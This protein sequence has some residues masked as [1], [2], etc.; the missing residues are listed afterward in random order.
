M[1][2]RRPKRQG[3]A[4][5]N[6][7]GR[8]SMN[9]V[10][11]A[12][13]RVACDVGGTFTDVCVLDEA[14][15]Q[16]RVAKTPTTPDP[17]DGVLEGIKAGGVDLRDMVLFAHGTT[18]ATNALI[19]RNFPP[20]DHGHHQGLP[21]RDR[22]PPRH[23]RRPVGHLQG[24]GAALHPAPQPTR[25]KRAHRL[26]RRR[27]RAGERGG[28]AGG[29]PHHQQAWRHDHRCLLRQR[30]RQSRERAPHARHSRRGSPRRFHLA[31]QRDHA[32]DLR[33]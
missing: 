30:L 17:I 31:L 12:A 16:M 2:R 3:D 1:L 26:Q 18:L 5:T 13:V 25:C 29:R 9:D 32:G 19:T 27:H 6:A 10:S 24:N 8:T 7:R 11:G 20:R 23:P 33:A 21:R 28:G 22:D 15:G 14:S 4:R